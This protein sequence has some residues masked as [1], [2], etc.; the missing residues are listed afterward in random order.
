MPFIGIS[1]I[2]FIVNNFQTI[3]KT[4]PR[5]HSMKHNLYCKKIWTILF[6]IKKI[7]TYIVLK[8]YV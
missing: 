3:I 6:Y 5:N 8:L 1:D 2:P 7:N 4:I